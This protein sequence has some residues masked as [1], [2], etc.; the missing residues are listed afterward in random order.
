MKHI[1]YIIY[2]FTFLFSQ[3]TQDF[4]LKDVKVEGNVVSSAN[5]I[6]FTSG[7]RKG[8]TVSTAEF[9]RAIK[10]LWQLGLFDDVQIR[11]DDENN[12]EISITLIVSESAVVG[13]VIYEGNRKI[14]ESKFT[15]EL[16]ITTGQRV[17]PNFLHE[18]MKQMK[19]LYAEKG[20]LKADINVELITSKKMSNLFDGKAKSITKDIIFK[21]KENEKIKLRNIYFEGNETYSDFRLRF[22]MKETKQQRWYYFWRTSYDNDKLDTDKEKINEFYQNKGHRD[23]SILSDSILY[24]GNSKYLDIVLHVDEGPKYKYRNFSWEGHS[25]YSENILSRALGLSKGEK[26]SEEDF[27]RAVYDRMQGLY[28]DKGY[29]YS[30][31]EPE[32]TPVGHD[33]LDIH[34]VISENHKVYI[35]NIFIKGNERTR[36]NVIRRIMR[37]YPGDVFNKER[38]LRTHREIMMLNY[39]GNVIPDVVPVD[40]DQ[41]DIEVTVEEKSSGQANMN[42]GFSQ[43]YGV[44]GGGGFS[45]PNYRGRGQHLAV[46]FEVGAA[47]Y[48][49]NYFGSGYTPQKRERASLSFT[50][51]M[52][53]DTNNLLSGSLFYSFSGRSSMYYAP[54]DQ[55]TK[56]GSIRWGRRFKWPDDYFRGSWSFTAHQRSYEA[57][58]EEQLLLYTG[59]L[60]QTVGISINQSISRD[61]RDHPE[62]PTI[63]SL[64]ALSSN[65]SGGPLGGNEDFHKHVLNLEWYT[66]TFWKFVLMSSVKIGG[67]KALPSNDSERSMV[68]FNERFIMGGSGMIYGNPLRGYEDNRVGPLTS[69]GGPFGGNALLKVTTEFR[70]PFSENPVVYGMVFAEMGNVWIESHLQEKFN[71]SRIGPIDLKRSAGLGIRFFMPMIGKLGF[72]FGYGFDDLNGDGEAEGWKSSITIGQQF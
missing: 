66:P 63:G 65:V 69:S 29:I 21:I 38:L 19:K 70:V 17:K 43:A 10:R 8:L 67:I 47:N 57:E 13:E 71:L 2:L 51:P 50:D 37:I 26:Y 58:S 42:M 5:T 61:S 11:Y 55:I 18:K 27:S 28:M 60:K 20:Y 53:N 34:F 32:V 4:L 30:R 48:N 56:G 24:D 12:N 72:D 35:R 54:L 3:S 44:T 45:L 9:P 39:F 46:S 49:Q 62:F 16:Q 59:G 31:I 52:V 15:E 22:L 14:K 1:V 7:L 25:L 23:F 6:I 64:M 41:V 36:E 68:P 40:D 33:S